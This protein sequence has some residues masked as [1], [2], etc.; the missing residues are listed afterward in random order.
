MSATLLAKLIEAGTP[1]ELVAE[2]AMELARSGVVHE[3][4]EKKRAYDRE[5]QRERRKDRTMSYDT[6][7]VVEK[8]SLEVSPHTPLPNP[9]KITPLSPPK[10][11]VEVPEWMPPSYV[12][13]RAMRKSMR[14]VPFGASAE[15]RVIAKIAKLKAEGH[16]PDKLISKAIE[17][18][19]RSVFEDET[20]KAKGPGAG[21]ELTAQQLRERAE[22]FVRHGQ[23]DRADECRRKAIERERVQAA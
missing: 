15:R 22:W 19:H 14:N 10:D 3:L 17:R 5:Y 9:S 23:Q 2:V 1:A 21:V 6:N 18:G 4:V 20:T 8:A 13:F 16:D 11:R 12:E 7:D